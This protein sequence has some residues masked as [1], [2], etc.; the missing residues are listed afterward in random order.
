MLQL[1]KSLSSNK[2]HSLLITHLIHIFSPP[3]PKEKQMVHKTGA[4]FTYHT[5]LGAMFFFWFHNVS[6]KKKLIAQVAKPK[7][8]ESI[9]PPNSSSLGI[10]LVKPKSK[11]RCYTSLEPLVSLYMFFCAHNSFY[12]GG[13]INRS[14]Y[15]YASYCWESLIS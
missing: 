4:P 3:H 7:R 10:F 12:P 14:M 5:I 6:Y 8:F 2:H 15:T 13:C 11:Q 9:K 1:N